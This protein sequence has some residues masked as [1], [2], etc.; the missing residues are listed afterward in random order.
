MKT[1]KFDDYYIVRLDKGEEIVTA[2]K[3]FCRAQ[4]I[5]L[6]TVSGIGAANRVKIGL[7]DPVEKKYHDQEFSGNFEIVSLSGN[8]TTMDGEVYLH[9]HIAVGDEKQRVY[10]GHLGQAVISAT[11]EIVVNIFNGEVNRY[12]D[13][14]VGL[15][16][17]NI[18]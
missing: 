4:N 6:G 13:D 15:N 10:G 9:L 5:K 14:E 2:L 17:L 11:A 16:L 12:F 3:K 18:A 7:F 8:I 1:R